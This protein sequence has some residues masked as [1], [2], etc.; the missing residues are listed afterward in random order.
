M[1]K[2]MVAWNNENIFGAYFWWLYLPSVIS[3][4]AAAIGPVHGRLLSGYDNACYWNGRDDV[5]LESERLS[6]VLLMK[7]DIPDALHTHLHCLC[8]IVAIFYVILPVVRRNEKRRNNEAAWRHENE[9]AAW[10]CIHYYIWPMM[11]LAM[12]EK[13][14]REWWW[15]GEKPVAWQWNGVNGGYVWVS[16]A[17]EMKWRLCCLPQPGDDDDRRYAWSH[18]YAFYF[19]TLGATWWC[20]VFSVAVPVRY[21]FLR[22]HATYLPC[23]SDAFSALFDLAAWSALSLPLFSHSLP[24]AGRWSALRDCSLAIAIAS[25]RA[26]CCLRFLRLS[27]TFA[28]VA[29]PHS[30]V[31]GARPLVHCRLSSVT[32]LP[33]FAFQCSA[34]HPVC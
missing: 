14:W 18:W 4:A 12:N 33:I 10:L 19:T 13:K 3:V 21:C 15:S 7:E 16:M 22:R 2:I 9:M 32:L 27:G 26:W 25:A 20:C 8:Y 17:N 31:P 11:F 23:S 34:E 29:L 30:S 6:D 1:K 28:D 24:I 5:L